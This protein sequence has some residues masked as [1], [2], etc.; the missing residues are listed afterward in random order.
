MIFGTDGVRG[1]AGV[2]PLRAQDVL[3]LGQLAAQIVPCR[4]ALIAHDTRR[5]AS[6][7]EASLAAGFAA[8]G[9]EHIHLAG[10]LPTPALA[11]MTAHEGYDLG[12]MITASHNPYADNGL[13]FFTAKGDKLSASQQR[14]LERAFEDE[15]DTLKSSSQPG[16]IEAK[17]GGLETYLDQLRTRLPDLD[18][19]GVRI[20]ID[21]A[22]GACAQG[23]P[24]LLASLGAQ[25]DTCGVTP[26]GI[27]INEKVGATHPATLAKLVGRCRADIG[28]AFDGDGDR[29]IVIDETGAIIDGEQILALLAVGLNKKNALKGKGIVS[30]VL[31]NSG[32]ETF[33][34]GHNLNLHRAPVGDQNV[35]KLMRETG[36]NFGGEPSGHLILSDHAPTGDGL[37]AGLQVLQMLREGEHPASTLCHVFD[38]VPHLEDLVRFSDRGA[39]QR[40]FEAPDFTQAVEAIKKEQNVH[41]LVRMSGTEPLVRLMIESDDP[42]YN[43][44]TT[45]TLKNILAR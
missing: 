35:L 24:L 28:L 32:L 34:T 39:A 9:I 16:V 10:V 44:R 6:M 27:N 21:C 40:A 29:V 2:Y 17:P 3:R 14:A 18:L 4:Q 5:S 1:P 42:T 19:T 11:A 20:A 30:T 23:A 41:L 22:H 8:A 37:F 33:L 25:I 38:P 31:A 36:C 13:K 43:A 45:E 12:V 26:D 7:L 15:T